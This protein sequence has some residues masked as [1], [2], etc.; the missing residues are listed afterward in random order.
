MSLIQV[1]N[2][3]FTYD[4]SY[5]TIF[6]HVS[7]QLDTDWKT[8]V[9]GRNGRG[10]T[11]FLRLLC[12]SYTYS[13]QIAAN[14]EFDCFP[15]EIPDEE[16]DTQ[17][18]ARSLLPDCEAWQLER[19]LNMLEV[20]LDVLERPFCTLS[21][22]ER[23]KVLLA[24][25]FLRENHFLLIDEPTNHLDLRAR[26]VVSAYLRRKRGFLLVSHDRAFLDDCVDHILSL[27]RTDIQV[28]KGNFSSWWENKQ[29]QD[30]FEVAQNEKLERDINRLEVAEARTSGWSDAMEKTKRGSRNSGLRPDTGY[31]GHKSAKMMKR[32]KSIEARQRE[33]I[34]QK[35][36][37][38]KNIEQIQPL[39]LSPLRYHADRLAELDD[40][41]IQYNGREICRP[42]N[43][44]V[45][46]GARIALQGRNGTGKSSL[47]KL[48]CG[49]DIP[50]TGM[51]HTG[52]RLIVS[53]VPQDAS[54][55]R[56]NL[57]EYAQ[58][59]GIDRSLFYAILRK[60]DFARTQFEKNMDDFS[61]GQKKKVLLAESL[62]R[63]AHL[64]IWDEPLNYIDVYSR[65]QIEQLLQECPSTMLFVEHDRAFCDAIATQKIELE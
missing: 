4:G 55:L 47:L 8:G 61:A 54:G 20:Q 44:L 64:Y 30:A 35:S 63:Q 60:L 38:R 42:V 15:Y 59:H 17:T 50:H 58:Q 37:L 23:T 9:V 6:D 28:Q 36:R 26:A 14:V 19:E 18:I 34:E 56:G 39:K 57:A 7:V 3:T 62:C 21:N 1:S 40:V 29:R 27:N 24:V 31:I 10:K 16:R 2:L 25:L 5:D 13:G 49:H 65:M 12:G 52:S 32:A 33:A 46:R 41:A 45:R 51:V 48:I 53:Y 11:T 43:L 22:G